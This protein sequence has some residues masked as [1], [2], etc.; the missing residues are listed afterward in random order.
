MTSIFSK[1]TTRIL[2]TGG[3]GFIGGALIRKLISNTNCSIFNLDKIS[4]A[5]D[6]QSIEIELEKHPDADLRY[7]LLKTDLSDLDSTKLSIE[8]S[9]PDIVFHLAAESHVDRSIKYPDSFLESNINGTY[10]L[11]ISLTDHWRNLDDM[12]K[13]NFRLLHVSTDEV[14]GSL[15][16]NGYFDEASKYDPRSPYSATKASSDHLVKAWNHTYNLPVLISNCSNNYGP[17]QFPEKLIP[18]TIHRALNQRDIP[19]YGNG[20]NIRDWIFVEDHV[21][22]LISIITKG[23]IGNNY[24]I[25][26]SSERTNI[27]LVETIC[28]LLDDIKPIKNPYKDFIKYVEDRPGHDYRYAIDSSLIRKDLG[29]Q[30][31]YKFDEGLVKTVLWYVHNQ[32]WAQCLLQ[33]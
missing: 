11:L 4:Y 33:S 21:D 5:S 13:K 23:I 9:N 26:A 6:F 16:S 17:W 30:P 19:I 31:K 32:E 8:I 15:G 27:Q 18:L 14:F 25:G 1:S 29:W 24:C 10:N 22:A 2:V 20:E 7:T 28:S 3:G 12:R